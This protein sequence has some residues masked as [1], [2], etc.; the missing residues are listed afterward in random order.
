MMGWFVALN[1]DVNIGASFGQISLIRWSRCANVPTVPFW[2]CGQSS[3]CGS[4]VT[5]DASE[6]SSSNQKKNKIKLFVM[7]KE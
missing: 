7:V 4:L 2:F 3:P 5:S 6:S 1:A